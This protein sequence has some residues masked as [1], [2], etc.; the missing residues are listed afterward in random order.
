MNRK[1]KIRLLMQ[2]KTGQRSPK[3]L[4]PKKVEIRMTI[5]TLKKG[6]PISEGF[7]EWNGIY[8]YRGRRLTG[9]EFKSYREANPQVEALT[10]HVLST[11]VPLAN[12]EDEAM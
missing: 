8:E 1:E 9:E 4:L 2:I 11:G 3:E 12:S 10:V 5:S 6:T 7:Y